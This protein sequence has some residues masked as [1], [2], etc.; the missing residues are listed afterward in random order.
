MGLGSLLVIV[1]HRAHLFS[2]GY[3]YAP[4]RILFSFRLHLGGTDLPPASKAEPAYAIL[5]KWSDP[6]P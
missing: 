2:T 5:K 3:R 6:H 4:L 1:R